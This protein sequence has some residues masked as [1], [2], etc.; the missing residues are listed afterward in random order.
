M[1]D[2]SPLFHDHRR[3]GELGL[4]LALPCPIQV[5]RL[6]ERREPRLRYQRKKQNPMKALCLIEWFRLPLASC[7]ARSWLDLSLWFI[8]CLV[9]TQPALA[10]TL[11][12]CSDPD[13]RAAISSGGRVS[14]AC[15]GTILLASEIIVD[16]DVVLDASGRQVVLSGLDANRLFTIRGGTALTLMHLTL[17]N[18]LATATNGTLAGPVGAGTGGAVLNL[19]GILTT[20]DCFFQSNVAVGLDGLALGGSPAGAGMGG[21]IATL[22]GV[23]RF[24]NTVFQRNSSVGG[25]GSVSIYASGGTGGASYGGAI[26]CE[27][28]AVTAD[29]CF[30]QTNSS[31]SGDGGSGHL[32]GGAGDCAGGAVLSTNGVV[33]L[34]SSILSSNSCRAGAAGNATGGAVYAAGGSL[35]AKNCLFAT[36]AVIAGPAKFPGGLLPGN[37]V[38]GAVWISTLSGDISGCAF[39]ANLASGGADGTLGP[40]RAYGIGGAVYSCQNLMIA[41]S[42]VFGNAAMCPAPSGPAPGVGGA[43]FNQGGTGMLI[44]VTVVSNAAQI[45]TNTAPAA[46]E[47]QSGPL[48]LRNCIIA[49][50]SVGGISCSN[51]VGDLIDGGGNFSSDSTPALTDPTSYNNVDPLVGALG[52]YG[53]STPTIP[54][55]LGSP[56]IGAANFA[57]CLPTDQR[58]YPRPYGTN[59][60]VG[61]F[62]FWPSNCVFGRIGGYVPSTGVMT[63]SAGAILAKVRADGTYGLGGL[64]VGESIV[65]PNCA[66]ALFVPGS[67]VV[68]MPPDFTGADFYSYQSNA[69]NMVAGS[70]SALTVRLAGRPGGT[71]RLLTSTNLQTWVPYTTNTANAAGL[72]DFA[73]TNPLTPSGSYFRATGL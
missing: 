40:G 42:T 24:T 48:T 28:G 11:T 21:A 50:S 7:A 53:G 20:I 18:G 72:A 63:V 52:S 19:G 71:Y 59:C 29:H 9:L 6:V 62:E 34:L 10:A 30:F 2:F 35:T 61:A 69:L 33:E 56:A 14:F 1:L 13:L 60:D 54:L 57:A 23:I 8:L 3:E 17:Q 64:P 45:G 65:V 25:P 5:E 70:A 22:G 15:D 44:H 68:N 55:L 26:Y 47:S 43:V 49:F 16:M 12:N 46:I 36:N 27:G 37:G 41:N 39:I 67:F 38:G 73:L 51:G 32:A 4:T 66:D 31:I 58:G